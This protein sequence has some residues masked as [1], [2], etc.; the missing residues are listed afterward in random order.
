MTMIEC[1][2]RDRHFDSGSGWTVES[3]L[4]DISGTFGEPRIETTWSRGTERLRDIRYLSPD[5][6]EDVANCEHYYWVEGVQ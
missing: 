4:T 2:E 3:S 1:V 5:G 6:G